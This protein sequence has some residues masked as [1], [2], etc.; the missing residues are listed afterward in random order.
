MSDAIWIRRTQRWLRDALSWRFETSVYTRAT[1]I[2][3]H[4]VETIQVIQDNED[5][6]IKGT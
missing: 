1:S 4:H 5:L 6:F 3:V 2:S